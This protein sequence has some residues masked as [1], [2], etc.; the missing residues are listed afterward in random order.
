VPAGDSLYRG[1]QRR[2]GTL[3]V[4]P[5]SRLDDFME[6]AK[7]LEND[8][9]EID[10]ARVV[11]VGTGHMPT[12]SLLFALGG[13]SVTTVDQ[14]RRLQWD[15]TSGVVSWLVEHRGEVVGALPTEALRERFDERIGIIEELSDSTETLE[16]LGVEYIAPGDPSE[17]S[18]GDGEVDV[19]FSTTE[20]EHLSKGVLAE[21]LIEASRVVGDSGVALHF[22]DLSDH[23]AHQDETISEVNFLQFSESEWDR[24]AGNQYSYCNRLY[25]SDYTR[26]IGDAGLVVTRDDREVDERSKQALSDGMQT[27]DAF[28]NMETDELATTSYRSMARGGAA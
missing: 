21:T 19:H 24:L 20:L 25:V 15:L 13:A 3:D 26:M 23:F 22:V 17:L 10:G 9:I 7:W 12:M 18:F 4:D 27:D 6:M 28:A 14:N 8:G 1:L 11:E 5:S 2:F 16:A